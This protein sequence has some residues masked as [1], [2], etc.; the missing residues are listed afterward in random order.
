GPPPDGEGG[1]F[2][3]DAAIDVNLNGPIFVPG[4]GADGCAGDVAL[5]A[6]GTITLS[7]MDLSGGLC[8][9]SFNVAT[10]GAASMRSAAEI[11]LD[12]TRSG[13]R[14]DVS[15]VANT[16][17]PGAASIPSSSQGNPRRSFPPR[18]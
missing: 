7:T 6:G 4:K 1:S 14:G 16:L 3:A 12:A 11:N 18:S 17:P 9:G 15:V 5:G 8:G 10:G 2:E 13:S